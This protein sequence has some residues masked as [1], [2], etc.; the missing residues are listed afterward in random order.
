VNLIL[1]IAWTH[2]RHRARQTLVAIAGVMT[3]VG[4][5]VMMAAMMEGSQD[6]FIKTLVDSLPHISVTDELREPTRQPADIL[7]RAAEFHG[8]T[9]E[10]RRPGIKNPMATIASLKTWVPGA[11][12][13]SV[14]SKAVLRFAG[15]NLTT[16]IVGIDP[17]TEADVSNLSTHMKQGTL[18]S[19]YRASNGI[20]LGDRLANKIGARVNSNITLASA[21]GGSM[22]ATVVGT[23]HSGFRATDETT[24]YVLLKTAQVLEKQT[25]IV[26]EIRVRTR[27]PMQAR[28]ISERIGEQTGYKSISWQE[29]Q[30]DLLSAITLRNVLMYTIVGA[31]LLVASFGTYN[32]ISTITHE[33]TRDIAILKSRGV[34]VDIRLSPHP[35]AGVAGIQDTFFRFQ[36]STG[37]LF[38]EA[39]FARYDRCLGVEHG[40]RLFSGPRRGAAA[41]G[42]YHPG[43]DMSAALIEARQVTKVLGGIVPVTLVRDINLAIMPR[44][45]IAITGPSGSG[46]SSL[47]YL[48][49]LLDLPTS[50]EILIDGRSTTTMTEKERARVRLTRLGFVFQFHFL[51]PEFSITENVALPM[52]GL[53]KLSPR[54]ITARAEELLDSFGLGDHRHKTP[55]QLS[56]GQQQ[57]V[58]VARALANDPPVILADEPTGSL[59]SA[60]TTQVFAILRDL[61]ALRGKTVVAVTHDLDLASQMHRGIHIVDG[62][63]VKD[64]R[65]VAAAATV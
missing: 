29:A 60:A 37:S 2:V 36:P 10:V 40:R 56:G 43:R 1:T 32:I 9:P 44:E 65:L 22:S 16:S 41:P 26:N 39:L 12:T 7:Y 38:G 23:F 46:K 28:L 24:G 19:L 33:K 14:Q 3:G 25:G 53:G 30:E 6:D 55:D 48:L 54:A 18:T 17:R 4:F 64:E 45:F 21:V 57:R 5:S 27:D 15:R 8:L 62:R 61:V 35:R 58:A 11:L 20:L 52:R 59:D 51:L 31:I 50:G 47:L 63:V 49:G 34:G 13:A 42:R